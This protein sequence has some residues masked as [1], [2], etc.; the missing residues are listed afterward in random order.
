MGT[1]ICAALRSGTL[2]NDTVECVLGQMVH[3]VGGWMQA[4]RLVGIADV[5]SMAII[6]LMFPMHRV[7]GCS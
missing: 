7:V 5:N 4:W 1:F 2:Y 3:F 6:E